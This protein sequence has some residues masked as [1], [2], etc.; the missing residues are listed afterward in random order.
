VSVIPAALARRGLTLVEL[1]VGLGCA[2]AVSGVAYRLLLTSPRVA[3]VQGERADLQDNVRAGALIVAAELRE[4]GFDSVP[5]NAPLGLPATASSDILIGEPGRIR[6]R[7]MRG[8]GFTCNAPSTGQILLRTATWRGQRLPVAEVDSLVLFVEGDPALSGDDAWVRAGIT[9]IA[10]GSC[11]DGAPAIALATSW[12]TAALG[13]GAAAGSVAGGPVRIFE[14]M[15][16]Q[17]Y[18]AAGMSWLG[19]RSVSRGEV[20]QPVIGPLADSSG[21]R[22]GLTLGYLDRSDSPTTLMSEVR[23]ITI[24]L[25]GVTAHPV[26]SVDLSRPTVDT[27][28]LATRVALRNM[29][30]P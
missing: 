8:L 25:R 12:E 28:D 24:G 29:M 11:A 9:G 13:A 6:Y 22:R 21:T 2:L 18:E 15:E 4:L 1:L 17:A 19:L 5:A 27:F 16:L 26:L 14:T 30:R 10:P 23:T 20:I 7:A 3:R